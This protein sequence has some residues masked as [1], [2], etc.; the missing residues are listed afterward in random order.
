MHIYIHNDY[1]VNEINRGGP[2]VIQLFFFRLISFF[3]TFFE[4]YI[5]RGLISVEGTQINLENESWG[6]P[7]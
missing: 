1:H 4:N 6:Y 2:L 5:A 3:L 7:N